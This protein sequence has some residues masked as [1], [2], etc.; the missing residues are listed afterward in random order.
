M[1]CHDTFF[2]FLFTIFKMECLLLTLYHEHTDGRPNRRTHKHR[3]TIVKI[4]IRYFKSES[5]YMFCPTYKFAHSIDCA[6]NSMKSLIAWAGQS[7]YWHPIYRQCCTFY[8]SK[9]NICYNKVHIPILHNKHYH[10]E[11]DYLGDSSHYSSN[12]YIVFH[13]P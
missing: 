9:L 11:C 13:T 2:V 1:V 10:R 4:M 6:L 8:G 12:I 7:I 3:N 5:I